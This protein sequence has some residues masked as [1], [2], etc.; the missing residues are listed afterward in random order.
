[1]ESRVAHFRQARKNNFILVHFSLDILGRCAKVEMYSGRR[2]SETPNKLEGMQ[3]MSTEIQYATPYS[4]DRCR[5]HR[6][7]NM[8]IAR[9]ARVPKGDCYY[10]VNIEIV[11]DAARRARFWNHLVI[12][13]GNDAYLWRLKQNLPTGR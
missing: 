1:M 10:R 6:D 9:L 11:I 12:R 3:V 7:E 5:W 4:P 8:K 13:G 2:E